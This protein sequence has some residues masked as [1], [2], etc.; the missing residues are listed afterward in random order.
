MTVF[1]VSILKNSLDQKAQMG[2]AF[3]EKHWKRA[4]LIRL[5]PGRAHGG[6]HACFQVKTSMEKTEHPCGGAIVM[7]PSCS[8]WKTKY[9]QSQLTTMR[10]Q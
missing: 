7:Q 6:K 1:S 9:K 2:T 3:S 10:K 8:L 5:A 4:V